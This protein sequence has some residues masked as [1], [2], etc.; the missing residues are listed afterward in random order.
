MLQLTQ[1]TSAPSAVS[2]SI[3][4]AVCT[5][6]CS[7]PATF[8]PFSGWDGPNS[9]R[10][11]IRPG[12]SCS[13]SSISLRPKAA[14]ERS[15]TLKSV[16]EPAVSGTRVM[17]TCSPSMGAC[18]TF[19]S[20]VASRRKMPA[21]A[22]A[23]DAVQRAEPLVDG[24]GE[25]RVGAHLALE[26]DLGDA[27]VVG[28]EQVAQLLQPLDLTGAVVPVAALGAQRRNEPGLFEIPKHPLRP[29]G[30]VGC[31]LDRERLHRGQ[32]YHGCVNFAGRPSL[33]GCRRSCACS[34]RSR[35]CR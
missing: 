25:D 18:G 34:R 19:C 7:E 16:T 6:M 11:A 5:V 23:A 27:Q 29:S 8:L 10:S 24:T 9:R 14:R 13:A 30:R 26:R 35:R 22:G 32:T 3:R 2:V 15:A 17:L 12:I 31:L 28:C 4:T 21:C 1:R 33:R 20:Y